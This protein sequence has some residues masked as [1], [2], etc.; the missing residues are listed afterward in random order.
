M[1]TNV[2]LMPHLDNNPQRQ[3][4]VEKAIKARDLADYHCYQKLEELLENFFTGADPKK[5]AKVF[6]MEREDVEEI[7]AEATEVVERR[8][9][10]NN[11][12]TAIVS[13]QK[14]D[15]SVIDVHN[16]EPS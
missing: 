3:A 14:Y 8:I 16:S 10:L 7:I 13:G 5:L 12:F 1:T 2:G 9:A 6:G 4:D 11:L 15:M